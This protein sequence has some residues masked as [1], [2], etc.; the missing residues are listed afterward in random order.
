MKNK[1]VEWKIS[2]TSNE[3]GDA[4]RLPYEDEAFFMELS[5]SKLL[6]GRK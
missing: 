5:G 1:K 2:D 4:L 6:V 3:K